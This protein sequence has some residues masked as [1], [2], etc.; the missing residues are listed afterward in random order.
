[1]ARW[2]YNHEDLRAMYAGGRGNTTARRWARFWAAV[3]G[4]GAFPRRWVT[5]EVPG[6]RSGRTTR[7]PLGLADWQGGWYLVSMLGDDCNWVRNVRAAD[8]R[9]TLRHGRARP[10][11]LVEVPVEERAAI[12]R[13][14]LQKVPGARPHIPVHRT[15][16]LAEF[17]AVAARYPVFRVDYAP[18]PARRRRRWLRLSLAAIVA[19]VVLLV[20]AVVAAVKLQ[21]VPSPLAL[22]ATAAPPAGTLD[23]AYQPAP[24]SL[25]G[26]RI[27]QTVLGLTS[28]VVG[29]TADIGGAATITAGRVT[30]ATLRIGLLALTSGNGKRAPQFDISLDTAHYPD[31]TVTLTQPA[32]LD[33]S[34]SSGAALPVTG[35]LTLHGITRPVTVTLSIRRDGAGLDVAGSVPVAFADFDLAAP[36]GYGAFGSLADHGTAEFLLLLQPRA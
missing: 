19:L 29:R 25:A 22:P 7:F 33:A 12:I 11:H 20:G 35:S 13:R 3:H 8:G 31:A 21:P 18:A 2:P 9:A 4:T 5:L 10:A 15:A 16:P 26:F 28:D 23:G 17:E 24:G 30:D 34:L 27:Q 6:R 36:Q 32:P 14:Y 1:M